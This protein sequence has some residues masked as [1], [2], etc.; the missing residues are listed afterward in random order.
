MR[1]YNEK[2]IVSFLKREKVLIPYIKERRKYFKRNEL[3]ANEFFTTPS[4]AFTWHNTPQGQKFWSLIHQ[5][6]LMF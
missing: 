1:K 6:F 5:K 3:R 2:M 4:A